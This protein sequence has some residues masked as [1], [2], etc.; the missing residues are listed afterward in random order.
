MS[1][2]PQKLLYSSESC[3]LHDR[4]HHWRLAAWCNV[5]VVSLIVFPFSILIHW[6]RSSQLVP[7]RDAMFL[8]LD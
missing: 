8:R 4:C 3:F 2:C 5:L 6:P 7:W 1:L